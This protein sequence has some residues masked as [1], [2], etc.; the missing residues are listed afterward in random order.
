[1]PEENKRKFPLWIHP[2]TLALVKEWYPKNN[3]QS[4]SEFIERAVRFYLGFLGA[5]D[6]EDYLLRSLS[7]VI[8]AT[9]QSS[10]DRMARMYYKI[11]VELSKLSHA[12]AYSHSIDPRDLRRLQAECQNEVARINGAVRFEDAY[13]FQHDEGTGNEV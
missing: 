12:V 10:E 9:V 8:S 4:Q 6:S 5:A 1:M 13:R 3:C 7:S 2:E 11:A